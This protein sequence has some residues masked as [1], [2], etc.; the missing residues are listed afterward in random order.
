MS[1]FERIRRIT[2]ANINLVLDKAENP[3]KMLKQR[4]RELEE[5]VAEAGKALAEYAVSFKKS[6][7]EQ[8]QLKR[9]RDEWRHKAETSLQAG[10]EETAKRALG[11]KVRAEER[12]AEIAPSVSRSKET[13]AGLKKNLT[14]LQDQLRDAR[15]KLAE[16]RS[17]KTAAGARKKFSETLDRAASAIGSGDAD[18]DRMEEQVLQAESKVE[19]DAEIKGDLT[20]VL[21]ETEKKSAELRVDAEL[22]AL[23][24]KMG[25]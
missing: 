12:I 7:R 23:K 11:E 18:F 2:Q 20:D 14:T 3:E 1:I 16:L 17:R 9:L 22:A 13:Y 15:V 21:A 5:T 19:I 4:I 10:D 24:K 25:K 6:E 8:D